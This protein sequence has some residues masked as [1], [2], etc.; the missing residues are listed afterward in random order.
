MSFLRNQAVTG[1]TFALVNKTSGAALTGGAGAV[2][3]YYTLD[4]G[5]QASI[6]GSVA[7]EGN[8]QYSVNLTAGEMNG[9][10]VGLLFTHASAIPIQFTIKTVGGSTTSSS[11]STLSLSFTGFRKE[12]GW[13]W[14]GDRTS[15]NWSSDET[16]QID[17]MIFAGL[18]QFYHP[19]P[20]PGQGLAHQWS[21]LE[22][23]T[24]LSTVAGTSDYTLPASFGGMVG[25]L[26]F[27]AGDNRWNAI[28][29]TNE[30]RI[31]ILRQRD[32]NSLRSHPISA[33]LRAR[34]SDGSDGQR[35]EILLW[36][37]PDKAYTL[38]YRYHALQAKLTTSNP[39]PLG[40]EIHAETILESCL[41]ITEQRLENNAGVHT[42]KFAERLAASISHDLQS[43]APEY[44]GYNGDRSDGLGPSENEF[45]RYFGSD[46]DY[47]G[48]I[49]YDTNPT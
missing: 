36:P 27:A 49:F 46:V 42:Q 38:S 40:G 13:L 4:G 14:L 10:V 45:R 2:S 33:A 20:L 31:R 6:S 7:E 35:F 11:E 18:R 44:M 9:A 47:D 19:P 28:D 29:I 25:P 3:K 22:P 5:T 21:F 39:Y 48:T 1:F 34:T 12:V 17:E 30:H 8:G 32:F 43:N 37:T 23:T 16:D 15:G 24:T 41:A 26:T